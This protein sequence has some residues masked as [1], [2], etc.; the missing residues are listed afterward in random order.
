MPRRTGFTL[1]ELLV[2]IAVIVLLAA[3]LFPVFAQARAKARQATC[4]SNIKQIGTAALLYAQ[5]YDE[6][7]LWDP[8]IN[9]FFGREPFLP[10]GPKDCP[11]RPIP[12]RSYYG[13][14]FWGDLLQPYVKNRRL[15]SCP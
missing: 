8:L 3:I 6:T 4:L 13:V 9:S 14:P 12:V 11:D 5:D 2:V 7:F 15:F 10:H 1:I